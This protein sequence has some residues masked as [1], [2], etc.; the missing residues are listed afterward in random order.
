MRTVLIA[1]GV[2][3]FLASTA[4]AQAID[5]SLRLHLEVPVLGYQSQEL[6]AD[7]ADD[8]AS[9]SIVT[10]GPSTSTLGFGLGYGLSDMLVLGT[11]VA[12]Q[13][14][15]VSPEEGDSA[16]TTSVQ[17]L[18][19]I[20]AV[21]GQGSARPFVGGNLMLQIRSGENTDAT[22]F[23][24]GALGGVHAFLN[25]WVSLDVSARIYYMT[26]TVTVDNGVAESD[27]DMSELGVLLLLGV[28]GWS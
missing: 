23:G 15:S 27:A 4:S 10:V 3:T 18:P 12:L 14:T 9:I 17:L 16:S 2:L 8:G 22:M 1:L 6:T 11:N 24:L 25:E 5:G 7:G 19:Y 13:H 26:G 20:E 28:S 21:F